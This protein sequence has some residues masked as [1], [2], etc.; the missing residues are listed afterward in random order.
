MENKN[1]KVD[2][3]ETYENPY[4]TI[5]KTSHGS[6]SY[7]AGHCL[8]EYNNELY[9]ADTLEE[10]INTDEGS[11]YNPSGAS[12]CSCVGEITEELGIP[13]IDE[14]NINVEYLYIDDVHKIG[15]NGQ[16]LHNV[17]EELKKKIKDLVSI[18][19]TYEND[20]TDGCNSIS[21][22][23]MPY[24]EINAS[25]EIS[26]GEIILHRGDDRSYILSEKTKEKTLSAPLISAEKKK[27]LLEILANQQNKIESQEK[28][29]ANLKEQRRN[30]NEK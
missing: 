9:L 17:D 18:S 20:I 26:N 21:K 8:L 14:E 2:A 25:L 3:F 16:L 6:E 23:T 10:I 4:N 24:G 15:E 5:N 28:E 22:N 30:L 1:I 13:W 27:E 7:Y 11:S 19:V 12:K 29:L